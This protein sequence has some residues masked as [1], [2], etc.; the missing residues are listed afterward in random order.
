MRREQAGAHKTSEAQNQKVDHPLDAIL[1]AKA[2]TRLAQIQ[3]ERGKSPPIDEVSCKTT[4]SMVYIRKVTKNWRHLCNQSAINIVEYCRSFK[5]HV[6]PPK[7][8]SLTYLVYSLRH[9]GSLCV[10]FRKIQEKCYWNF[11][12][13]TKYSTYPSKTNDHLIPPKVFGISF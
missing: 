1:L 9:L 5:L 3:K 6:F 13:H 8:I 4:W 10:T 11:K 2:V 12:W 7:Y